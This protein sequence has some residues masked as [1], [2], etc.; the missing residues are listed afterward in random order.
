MRARDAIL[1]STINDEIDAIEQPWTERSENRMF[2]NNED[3]SVRVLNA[4]GIII[5]NEKNADFRRGIVCAT[6]VS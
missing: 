6:R 3:F 4:R 1:I 5:D 2:G